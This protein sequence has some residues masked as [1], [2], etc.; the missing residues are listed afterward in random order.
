MKTM[1][2]RKFSRANFCALFLLLGLTT[3]HLPWTAAKAQTSPTAPIGDRATVA[4][5][6]VNLDPAFFV[7]GYGGKCL[8]FGPPPQVSGAPVFIYDC[9]GTV[10]Q[11]VRVEEIN[12]RHDIIL[13]AGDKV[14][15]VKSVLVIAPPEQSATQL[16]AQLE[17]ETPLDR[18]YPNS[19]F[20]I[21]SSSRPARSFFKLRVKRSAGADDRLTVSPL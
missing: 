13:R 12:S 20:T 9:N 5:P 10:A 17:T 2:L 16:V 11:Q 21:P 1:S 6:M 18:Q 8:D 4:E 7:R 15:S 19:S 14:I 3:L